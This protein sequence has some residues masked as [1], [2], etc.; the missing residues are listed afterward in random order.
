MGTQP[1]SSIF[2]LHYSKSNIRSTKERVS[3][4]TPNEPQDMN[5][6]HTKKGV[7]LGLP[8]MSP[9]FRPGTQSTKK[10]GVPALNYG[11]IRGGP[12][13]CSP[14]ANQHTTNSN[15]DPN[16]MSLRRVQTHK[17]MFTECI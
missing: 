2:K 3:T 1:T 8:L 10:G 12:L 11:P 5:T 6:V 7:Y 16:P 14:N 15:I 4:P 9:K 13:M 17:I